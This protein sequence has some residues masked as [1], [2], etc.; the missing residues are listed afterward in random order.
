MRSLFH[1]PAPEDEALRINKYFTEN[2]S[3]FS[4]SVYLDLMHELQKTSA[5]EDDR[6][7]AAHYKTFSTLDEHRHRSIRAS[8]G[9]TDTFHEP[10]LLS[11]DIGWN[12]KEKPIGF[13][14]FPKKHCEETK[15]MSK[16]FASG[17]I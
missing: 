2:G 6:E 10:L 16:L 11:Q 3:T 9:P 1:G 13:S 14:K 7:K 15:F 17:L 12:A 4:F 8:Y 5:C